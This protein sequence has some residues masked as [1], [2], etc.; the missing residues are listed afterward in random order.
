MGSPRSVGRF[1][2]RR[3]ERLTNRI[4]GTLLAGLDT[5][6]KRIKPGLKVIR[7]AVTLRCMFGSPASGI[8]CSMSRR[9]CA[10]GVLAKHGSTFLGPRS[11]SI[12]SKCAGPQ[13]DKRSFFAVNRASASIDLT[14]N[15][16]GTESLGN[17]RRGVVTIVKSNSL[18]NKRTCRNLDGTKR[19]KAGLVVII[20]SGRVSVTRGRNKL[21]RGLGRLH[22]ARK[23]SSY[24]FFHSLKLSCLCIKRKGSVPSLITTFTGIGSASHPAIIRVRARG[25][26]KCTPTRTSQR[27]F[28]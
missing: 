11:C 16:T 9:D 25:K 20:G 8:M 14:Y 15:L 1:S 19:V 2:I 10:R 26:G 3:L 23:Q 13:R 7:T 24:G 12:I 6:K 17:K 4:H 22:S 21:C 27:R 5:R 28:R 18:D